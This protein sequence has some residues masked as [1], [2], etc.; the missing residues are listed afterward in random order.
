MKPRTLLILFLVTAALGAFIWFYERDLPSSEERAELGRKLLRDVEQDEVT[1][2]E[3][4]WDGERVR[5]EKVGPEPPA[6]DD[7]DAETAGGDGEAAPATE[8]GAVGEAEWRLIAPAAIAPA[9]ADRLAVDGLV[10]SLLALEKSRTVEDADRATSGL[11]EP[12][13]TVTLVTGRGDGAAETVLEIGAEVPASSSTLA[14]LAGTPEVYVVDG[15]IYSQVTRAPGDWRDRQIWSARRDEIDR[16]ELVPAGGPAV[17]LARRGEDFW[18]DSPRVDRADRSA[19]EQLMT[20]LVGLSAQRFVDAP[21]D[22][23]ELGLEPPQA[24]LTAVLGGG[25]EPFRLELG[26]STGA[27]SGAG[28]HYARAGD[29]VFVLASDLPRLAEHA[30]ADWQSKNLSGRRLYQ[31]DRFTVERPAESGAPSVLLGRSGSDWTRGDD[32]IAYTPVSDFLFAITD[33]RADRLV[34]RDEAAGL[35]A[36]LATPTLRVTFEGGDATTGDET[37]ALYPPLAGDDARVPAT[38]SGRDFVLLLPPGTAAEIAD[39]LDVLLTAEPLPAA[40][41]TAAAD[42]LEDLAIEV[43]EGDGEPPDG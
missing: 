23:A 40:D 13:A 29:Q 12:R 36:D 32:A 41:E 9:R 7:S 28:A 19:V 38:A 30:P 5:L 27:E 33:A 18:L 15:S 31:I 35:G 14:A 6:A 24:V 22:L 42:D 4:V 26:G 20:D 1:A 2:L 39:T 8:L 43:E 10:D 37:V 3:L 17:V 25:A 34:R 11:D 16:L 21:E